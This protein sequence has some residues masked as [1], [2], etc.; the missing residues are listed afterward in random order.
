MTIDWTKIRAD[1]P[2]LARQVHGKPL[3]DS[4]WVQLNLARVHAKAEVL[5]L[6]NWELASADSSPSPVIAR[7]P[8]VRSRRRGGPP[9]RDPASAGHSPV[10]PA[11]THCTISTDGAP[12]ASITSRSMLRGDILSAASRLSTCW[13]KSDRLP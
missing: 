11:G 7:E 5:K 2:L 6:I 4:Q 10:P 12:V 13:S 3:I 9:C 8:L 1:F